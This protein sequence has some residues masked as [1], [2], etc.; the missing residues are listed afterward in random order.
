V[1]GER[2]SRSRSYQKNANRLVEQKNDP[3]VRQYVGQLCLDTPE[4]VAALDALYEQMWLYY[5][6]FQPVL[7]LCEKMM[8]TDQVVR[9]WMKPRRP[10]SAC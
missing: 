6:V 8:V 9:K 1:T 4:Q 5:N 3:V 2:L 10:M 7:H